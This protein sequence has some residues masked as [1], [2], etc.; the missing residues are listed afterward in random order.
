MEV[1]RN[2]SAICYDQIKDDYWYAE[3]LGLKVVMVKKDGWKDDYI[4][5]RYLCFLGGTRLTNWQDNVHSKDIL[6]FYVKKLN[7]VEVRIPAH[8]NKMVHNNLLGS[9]A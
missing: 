6:N 9:V 8:A 7:L 3:C 1:A 4:N 2:I 5:G